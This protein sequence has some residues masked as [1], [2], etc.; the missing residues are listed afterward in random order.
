MICGKTATGFAFKV[1]KNVLD[2]ME[3]VDTLA[4]MQEDNPLAVSA[5]VRLLLGEVQRKALYDHLRAPDGRV[6]I[7]AVTDAVKDV[8]AALG[9]PAK[10]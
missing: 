1:P 7:V 6:P 5:V 2:N 10:N 4:E 8:F 3:L 9:S